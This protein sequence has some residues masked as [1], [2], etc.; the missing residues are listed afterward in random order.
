MNRQIFAAIFLALPLAGTFCI[1]QTPVPIEEDYRK[2]VLYLLEITGAEAIAVQV[3]TAVANQV[4]DTVVSQHGEV[5]DE[6]RT[7]AHEE[8]E[9]IMREEMA[10]MLDHFVP[11]YA[12]YFTHDE[13]RSL[14]EF[15]ESPIGKKTISVLPQLMQDAMT[16][17]QK[18]GEAMG[19]DVTARF[20]RRLQEEGLIPTAS[21]E[22]AETDD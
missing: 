21:G 1:A 10:K 11:L 22:S 13:I 12:K 16:F 14:I 20:T 19:P 9:S 5:S 2:D 3:G 18:W 17:G 4:F 6:V 7:I 8:L 15:Y